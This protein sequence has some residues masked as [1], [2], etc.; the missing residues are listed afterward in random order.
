M[1]DASRCDSCERR[2][3]GWQAKYRIFIAISLK[4]MVRQ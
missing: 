4:K 2:L 3:A 1:I